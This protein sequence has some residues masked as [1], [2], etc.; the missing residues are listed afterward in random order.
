MRERKSVVYPAKFG[1]IRDMNTSFSMGKMQIAYHGRN[2][3]GMTIPKEAFEKSLSSIYNRPIVANYLEE[4]DSIGGHDVEFVRNDKGIAM[5]N[6]T[7]PVGV[8]PESANVWWEM[9]EDK[10][11]TE[12]EYLCCDVLLWKRQKAY[13]HLKE[14]VVT[15]QSMEIDILQRH[16]DDE[17]N[18]HIDLFEFTAFCLLERDRPC[19]PSASVTL[20]SMDSCRTKFDE[21]MQDFAR[22]F[23]QVIAA[24][25][26]DIDT[27]I[28]SKGGDRKMNIEEMLTHYGLSA[29]D[30]TFET[31]GMEQ[32]EL[33]QRFAQLRDEKQNGASEPEVPEVEPAPA[34]PESNPEPE[35]PAQSEQ[36]SLSV[37]QFMSELRKELRT[38]MMDD[39]WFEGQYPR[40]WYTDCDMEAGEVFAYDDMDGNLYG[41]PYSMEGDKV[42]INFA[43]GKRKKIMYADFDE[44][45]TSME[46]SL[47]KDVR[48]DLRTKFDAVNETCAEL[49]RFKDETL[50]EQLRHDQEKVF[51]M[52]E[53]M[54]GNEQFDALRA[55]CGN[56]SV[57][58]LEEKCYALRG[59][60]GVQ[61]FSAAPAPEALRLPV[62]QDHGAAEVDPNEPYGG[63]FVE[64]GIGR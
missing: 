8:V 37:E 54:A 47:V 18:V 42:V 23:T 46:F 24:S 26:D 5:V 50:A 27:Q 28:F 6:V 55:D 7:E 62:D 25:A 19:F 14:N 57:E 16:I 12:R 4:D 15:D 1:A 33:E 48:T 17:G 30:V 40:Y 32:S 22:E 35:Q 49:K 51:A 11:G 20:F 29:E 58:E 3:N 39:P 38:V 13:S 21:M 36:F 41:F 34:E 59:R 64:Y 45:T 53:D 56:M 43:A 2:N 63:I 10:D 52:F 31:S 60:F 9:I 44:G 61:K